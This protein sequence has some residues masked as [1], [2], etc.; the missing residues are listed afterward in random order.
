MIKISGTREGWPA[1]ERCLEE[2]ININVTLLLSVQASGGSLLQPQGKA[3]LAGA[4]LAYETFTEMT[5]TP[6]WR[7]LEAKGAQ[8]QRLLWASTGTKNPRYP[9]V[10]SVESL[11]GADTIATVPP[12]TLRR[13]EDHSQIS[14]ALSSGS[15]G[16]AQAVMDALA[17]GAIDFTDVNR[18]LEQEGIGKF[19]T[20]FD[21]LLAAIAK[22]RRQ[23]SHR[24]DE[25]GSAPVSSEGGR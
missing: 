7:A 21:R 1:I 24:A 12:D 18:T 16:D 11:I 6:R 8:L 10:M 9:A 19:T 17:A 25:P 23:M 5:R 4:R 22:K 14:N 15:A 3:A 13:F 20:S 2:A